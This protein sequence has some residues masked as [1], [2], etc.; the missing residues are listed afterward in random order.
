MVKIQLFFSLLGSGVW[1]EVGW[2]SWN[3]FG[4]FR[5]AP[6]LYFALCSFID[7]TGASDAGL[8]A[9]DAGLAASAP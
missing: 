8:A 7:Y 2:E 1:R 4:P 9:S 3:F 5:G 6:G